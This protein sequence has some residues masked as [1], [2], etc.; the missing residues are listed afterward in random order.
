[1]FDM[2]EIDFKFQ[3][4]KTVN[5]RPDPDGAARALKV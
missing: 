3:L 1:M 2:E 5:Q 4:R